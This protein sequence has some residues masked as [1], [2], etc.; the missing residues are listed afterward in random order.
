MSRILTS[1]LRTPLRTALRQHGPLSLGARPL[2]STTAAAAAGGSDGK[3]RFLLESE[4]TG[5]GFVRS[6]PVRA[7]PRKLGMTEIRGPYYASYGARHLADV[8]ETMGAHVDGL[9]FAGG[10]FALMPENRVK[11]LTA[12]AHQYGVYCSTGGFIEHLLTQHDVHT[13]VDRYLRKCKDLG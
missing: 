12:L 10:S 13:V 5:L 7:K 6:N 8:L 2:S 1:S 4:D 9:K 3:P 11:E